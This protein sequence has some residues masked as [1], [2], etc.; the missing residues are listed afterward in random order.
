MES[1]ECVV[2]EATVVHPENEANI[3]V[4][5]QVEVLHVVNA[6]EA[7]ENAAN[8]AVTED[9][10]MLRRIRARKH[11]RLN[12]FVLRLCIS[13]AIVALNFAGA[14]VLAGASEACPTHPVPWSTF[15]LVN[16]T[17]GLI[18]MSG[19]ILS[20]W[21]L[22]LIG[23][24]NI[25]MAVAH[26]K[27][28]NELAAASAHQV[29]LGE[30]KKGMRIAKLVK[31]P[32]ILALLF[33]LSWG[34]V[35][36]VV[37]AS[38]RGDIV[39]QCQ[40]LERWFMM[41]FVGAL[42]ISAMAQV[43]QA[44]SKETP[45]EA[46]V[47]AAKA[48]R[49]VLNRVTPTTR[50][51]GPVK[52]MYDTQG[53]NAHTQLLAAVRRL[54]SS[55]EHESYSAEEMARLIESEVTRIRNGEFEAPREE[56]S[57]YGPHPP[58]YIELKPLG[59]LGSGGF[60]FVGLVEH[61]ASSRCYA[62][63]TKWKG[64]MCQSGMVASAV[65]EK[66]VLTTARSPFVIRFY[67]SYDQS[68]CVHFLNEPCLGGEIYTLYKRRGL[69][70][71]VEHARFYSAC[72]VEALQHLH[73][74][75]ILCRAV[76]PEDCCVDS[77]G[78]LKLIDF[79]LSKFIIGKTY[80]TC[81]TPDYFAPE[82]IATQGHDFAVDWWCSG[83]LLFEFMAG[84]PPF[85]SAYPMQIYSKVM[86]GIEKVSF[87]VIDNKSKSCVAL[88]KELCKAKPESRLPMLPDGLTK[89]KAHKWFD[90][91]D[92]AGLQSQTLSPPYKPQLAS[93][94]DLRMF[95]PSADDVPRAAPFGGGFLDWQMEFGND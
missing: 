83:V 36:W 77:A 74:M 60:A 19:T 72:V 30:L 55:S 94:R 40:E 89:L 29:G 51:P 81:G 76:K 63:K 28:G 57:Q 79:D 69:H 70:R 44:C 8:L 37:Y 56:W 45:Q 58:P 62:L 47:G 50:A 18:L 11:S 24:D 16:A 49:N 10:D 39:L 53:A 25:L 75:R 59:L 80:T 92:W 42:L 1:N 22:V 27:K 9:E 61:Q 41:S 21:S 85:E 17:S 13:F 65:H 78:W 34:I 82:I 26:R 38:S 68:N 95:S 43:E 67:G 14:F 48:Y 84:H 35:G 4:E 54:L 86:K 52:D 73:S 66:M 15:F 32:M 31:R 71:S 46:S 12:C 6:S 90:G 33:A 64:T 7:K 20:L 23:N 87:S 93:A 91:L 5:G 88:I 3:D 2:V